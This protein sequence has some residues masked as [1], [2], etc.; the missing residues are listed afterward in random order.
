[1]YDL[2][3]WY[4]WPRFKNATM[5]YSSKNF[6]LVDF[7]RDSTKHAS[8]MV[9]LSMDVKIDNLRDKNDIIWNEPIMRLFNMLDRLS[10]EHTILCE[11]DSD[12]ECVMWQRDSLMFRDR[13]V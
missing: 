11:S 10:Y 7:C 12:M 6:N 9:V 1:M 3:K 2:G 5:V 13:T 4:L 8:M